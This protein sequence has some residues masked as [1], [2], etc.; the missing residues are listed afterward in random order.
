M[1]LTSSDSTSGDQFIEHRV[2]ADQFRP[3]IGHRQRFGPAGR[4]WVDG[5]D[6]A[7]SRAL[8]QKR[9]PDRNRKILPLR[10]AHAEVRQ[11]R[12]VSGHTAIGG[13]RLV[14]KQHGARATAAAELAR[15]TFNDV[16]VFGSQRRTAQFAPRVGPA[17][18]AGERAK[19][20]QR[21][22]KHGRHAGA[23]RFRVEF[24]EPTAAPGRQTR[25]AW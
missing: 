3:R 25:W 7:G 18:A 22:G 10:I 1:R 8:E 17:W 23:Y 14:A 11:K 19:S 15:G 21:F 20:S 4:A 5:H 2:L 24:D 13:R 12:E 6:A 9:Q 16:F